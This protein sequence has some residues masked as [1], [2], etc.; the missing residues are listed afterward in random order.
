MNLGAYEFAN[1]ISPI[2]SL[3]FSPTTTIAVTQIFSRRQRGRGPRAAAQSTRVP[4]G[5]A[6][7]GAED[8]IRA[9]R[10]VAGRARLSAQTAQPALSPALIQ[11]SL[12]MSV[13]GHR[14]ASLKTPD[15]ERQGLGQ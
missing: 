9:H 1:E 14:S 12:T 11:E 6:E 13:A 2:E 7:S 15:P 3:E 5:L 8:P 10:S 4:H